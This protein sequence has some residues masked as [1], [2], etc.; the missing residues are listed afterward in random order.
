MF[1]VRSLTRIVTIA[2]SLALS[3]SLAT[4]AAEASTAASAGQFTA[5]SGCNR[6]THQMSVGGSVLVDANRFPNGASIA[7][8]YAYW[9]VDGSMRPITAPRTTGWY[10]ARTG[11]PILYNSS[12]LFGADTYSNPYDLSVYVF[13]TTG[14]LQ[15]EAQVGVWNGTAYEWLPWDVVRSYHN[16]GSWRD[17]TFDASVCVASA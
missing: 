14:H 13:N 3:L 11:A 17:Q 12:T 16:I 6:S 7:Y 10:Y 5:W 9:Y 8:R 4:G 1:H 15:A 2:A